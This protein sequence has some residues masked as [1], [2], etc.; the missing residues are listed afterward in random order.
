MRLQVFLAKCN[1]ASRRKAEEII[2]SGRV[3]VNNRKITEQGIQ[4]DPQKDNVTLDG[5]KLTFITD[6]IYIMLNKPVGY[7]TTKADPHAEHTV[8]DLIPK[9]LHS[10]H[11]V[12]RLDKLTQGLVLLTNDGELTYNLTHP[13][14]EVDKIYKVTIR[15][16][17]NKEDKA[18]LE[19][20]IILENKKTAACSIYDL[21]TDKNQTVFMLKIHEGRKRQIRHML[22]SCGYS[23]IGLTRLEIGGLSL[24]NLKEGAWRLLRPDE[25]KNLQDKA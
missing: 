6:K 10:V 24:G 22:L 12:G 7:T 15:G 11:P 23:V 1:I 3:T 16:V 20:G 21:K 14:F 17:L 5:K 13:K 19:H 25:V 18:Q 9:H 2:A 8:L 4:V